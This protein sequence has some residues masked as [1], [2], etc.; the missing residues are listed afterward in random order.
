M[1][2]GKGKRERAAVAPAAGPPYH[3]VS[4]WWVLKLKMD[5]SFGG[6]WIREQN[7]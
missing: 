1:G 2:A 4:L 6:G 7:D 3:L 5:T